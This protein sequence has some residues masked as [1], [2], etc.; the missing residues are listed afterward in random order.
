MMAMGGLATLAASVLAAVL[1][2]R[3][4]SQPLERLAGAAGRIERNDL[5][6][7]EPLSGSRI[8]ASAETLRQAGGVPSRSVGEIVLK[9]RSE[10]LPVYE[11]FADGPPAW[12]EKY[13]SAYRRLKEGASGALSAFADLARETP[14][15]GVVRFHYSRLQTGLTT[16]VVELT[17]K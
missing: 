10:A 4:L 5:E 2:G 8:L 1:M 14:E 13:Q 16:P 6:D 12:L 9:G 3:R 15:D 11:V 7:F 17:E